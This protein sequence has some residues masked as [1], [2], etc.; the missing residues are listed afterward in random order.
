[1]VKEMG[2]KNLSS[3]IQGDQ[4]RVT[5]KQRDDLQKAIA[6]FKESDLAVPCSS[7]TSGLSPGHL[8]D[9]EVLVDL[10]DRSTRN[11]RLKT[12]SFNTQKMAKLARL[13]KTTSP[14]LAR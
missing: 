7:P 8:F 11:I 6:F 2:V 1:M 10:F 3:S 12:M 4:V 9:V 14:V 5:G 13:V